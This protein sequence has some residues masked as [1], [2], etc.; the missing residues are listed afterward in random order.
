M[1]L[2]SDNVIKIPITA[3][4]QA[5]SFGAYQSTNPLSTHWDRVTHTWWR[6]QMEAFSALLAFGAGNSRYRWIPHTKASD[7]ENWCFFYLCLNQQLSKQWRRR[8]FETPSLS[9]WRNC[10]V[11]VSLEYAIIGSDNG[12]TTIQ[13]QNFTWTNAGSLSDEPLE[14]NF[15]EMWIKNSNFHLIK[16]K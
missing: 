6:H 16:C 14:T 7:A 5:L 10:N 12:L 1:L 15:R 11:Y 13:C 2:P 8:W 9:L 4:Q 3:K